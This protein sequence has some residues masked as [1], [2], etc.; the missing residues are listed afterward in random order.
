MTFFRA[1]ESVTS[2]EPYGKSLRTP[3]GPAIKS[4]NSIAELGKTRSFL[5]Y[6]AFALSPVMRRNE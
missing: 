1:Q 6:M 3:F 2:V 5:H 4:W